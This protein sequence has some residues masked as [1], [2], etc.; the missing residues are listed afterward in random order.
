M[1]TVIMV[2]KA[3]QGKESYRSINSQFGY[4]K[5]KIKG[6]I[7]LCINLPFINYSL[8]VISANLFSICFGVNPTVSSAQFKRGQ[9]RHR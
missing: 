8:N 3:K 7:K 5:D 9:K 2:K 4:R 1:D 6:R